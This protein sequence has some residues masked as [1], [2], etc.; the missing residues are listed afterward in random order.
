MQD[1]L[2]ALG[3]LHVGL[4]EI[5]AEIAAR[6]NA[7]RLCIVCRD[8]GRPDDMNEAPRQTDP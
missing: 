2:A 3:Q 4:R 7:G 6:Y 8:T 1:L 5:H